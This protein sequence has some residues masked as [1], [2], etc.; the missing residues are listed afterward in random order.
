MK[1]FERVRELGPESEAEKEKYLISY[2]MLAL[3]AL[4]IGYERSND[5]DKAVSVLEE[6]LRQYPNSKVA[7]EKLSKLNGSIDK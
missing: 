3:R 4:A 6:L 7:E 1:C 5:I 2:H